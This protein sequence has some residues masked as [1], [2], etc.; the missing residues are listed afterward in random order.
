MREG[1]LQ[2]SY[3]TGALKVNYRKPV[4]VDRPVEL[5]ARVAEF[6]ERKVAV[7]CDVLTDGVLAADAE[8]LAV[9]VSPSRS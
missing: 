7:K 4:P 5:R 9:R 8:V 1:G 3:V 6:A 2:H